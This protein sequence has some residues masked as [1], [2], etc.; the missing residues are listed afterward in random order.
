MPFPYKRKP[1][2]LAGFLHLAF[3]FAGVSVFAPE[4]VDQVIVLGAMLPIVERG[5]SMDST[6][7]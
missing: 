5:Q 1:R 3:C 4:P 7:A 2:W 6:L